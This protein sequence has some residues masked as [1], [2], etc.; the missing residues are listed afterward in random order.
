M[1]HHLVH[2]KTYLE[3]WKLNGIQKRWLGIKVKRERSTRQLHVNVMFD[4]TL[5]H[6][7]CDASTTMKSCTCCTA[8]LGCLIFPNQHH[9]QCCR[10]RGDF[11]FGVVICVTLLLCQS[12]FVLVSFF[13]AMLLLLCS[14]LQFQCCCSCDALASVAVASI[15]VLLLVQYICGWGCSFNLV[16][17]F[18]Q[19]ACEWGCC[20]NWGS[21]VHMTL[22]QFWLLFD[23]GA[24]VFVPLSLSPLFSI[25]VLLIVQCSCC[26]GHCFDFGVVFSG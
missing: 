20:F 17:L 15:L 12:L 24:V 19:C 22:K 14:L 2:S 21:V 3:A 10:S 11:N 6:L 16:V 8:S 18:L 1:F 7:P 23:F 25:L 9:S 5:Q 26:L 13:C 4:K